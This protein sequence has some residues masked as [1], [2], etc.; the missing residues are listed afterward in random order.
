MSEID[1][2]AG[3]GVGQPDLTEFGQPPAVG[4]PRVPAISPL[5]PDATREFRHLRDGSTVHINNHYVGTHTGNWISADDTNFDAENAYRLDIYEIDVDDPA[6]VDTLY[7]ATNRDWDVPAKYLTG[8]LDQP[9]VAKNLRVVNETPPEQTDVDAINTLEQAVGRRV[10]L[11]D[12]KVADKVRVV[13]VDTVRDGVVYLTPDSPGNGAYWV[14]EEPEYRSDL[15]KSDVA[16]HN[17]TYGSQ[18]AVPPRMDLPVGD[19]RLTEDGLV[20]HGLGFRSQAVDAVERVANQFYSDPDQVDDNWDVGSLDH[21]WDLSGSLSP[22]SVPAPGEDITG[23]TGIG[24]KTALKMSGY[25]TH[26]TKSI[27][28]SKAKSRLEDDETVEVR[29]L[30]DGEVADDLQAAQEAYEPPEGDRSPDLYTVEDV[31]AGKVPLFDL[32]RFFLAAVAKARTALVDDDPSVMDLMLVHA[33]ATNGTLYDEDGTKVLSYPELY[34]SD[35]PDTTPAF[36]AA[37][38]VRKHG[39]PL[40]HDGVTFGLT[41]LRPTR[42]RAGLLEDAN[43][44]YTAK[45]EE[46]GPP[47]QLAELTDI[48]AAEFV[49][50]THAELNAGVNNVA[51]FRA[52]EEAPWNESDDEDGP[53]VELATFSNDGAADASADQVDSL[54]SDLRDAHLM[55]LSGEV[56]EYLMTLF[57]EDLLGASPNA[58]VTP[59]SLYVDTTSDTVAIAHPD[60]DCWAYATPTR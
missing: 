58:S 27:S 40:E 45:F 28:P 22:S 9:A 38:G 34:F 46:N 19:Y 39:P 11:N 52:P 15:D 4:D 51:L 14:A 50:V 41:T 13:Q 36:A 31:L 44:I 2:A 53:A 24:E 55:S 42:M 30:D 33:A 7:L 47:W 1:A 12:R 10:L 57:G 26:G 20:P 48:N 60:L 17:I 43:N 6:D 54:P 56:L 29:E 8:H 3:A 16:T 35:R 59:D 25:Q 49:E 5:N 37:G 18:W 32:G 23:L 21:S